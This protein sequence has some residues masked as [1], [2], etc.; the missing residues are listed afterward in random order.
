MFINLRLKRACNNL[1]AHTAMGSLGRRRQISE[2]SFL[3]FVTPDT[4]KAPNSIRKKSE[5]EKTNE[6][7]KFNAKGS[8]DHRV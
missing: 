8:R 7:G 1:M 4:L 6:R 5:R 2:M 3:P